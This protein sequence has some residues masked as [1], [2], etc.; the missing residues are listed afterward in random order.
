[1]ERL[2]DVAYVCYEQGFNETLAQVKYFSSGNSIDLSRVDRERK[3]A[4]I[5]VEEALTDRNAQEVVVGS[6]V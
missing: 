1:M 6:I 2:E 3:L 5:L 4:E